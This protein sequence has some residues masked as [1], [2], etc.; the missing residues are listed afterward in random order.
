MISLKLIDDL[1]L[2]KILGAIALLDIINP[3]K[4]LEFFF[5]K[6]LILVLKALV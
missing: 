6:F 3:I 1:I 4:L 5:E 2:P